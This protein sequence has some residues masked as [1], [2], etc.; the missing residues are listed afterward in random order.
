MKTPVRW[1]I[2]VLLVAVALL[3]LITAQDIRAN[4]AVR[5]TP[6]AI[7]NAVDTGEVAAL[8]RAAA[9][10]RIEASDLQPSLAFIAG[11]NDG[12]DFRLA[13]LLRA[14]LAYAHAFSPAADTALKAQLLAFP[15]WMDARGSGG[16]MVY[17]SEN[18]QALFSSAEFL[19]GGLY[20]DVRF[21]DG[22]T[23]AA[24]RA[25]A[26]GRLLFWLD[27]R[28]RYGFS[29]WN[30]HYYGEDI[31][32]LTNLIDFAGDAEIARKAE[33]IL[34]LLMADLATHAIK[35]EFIAASGRLYET[36]AKTGDEGVR[37]V[38][39]HAF[40]QPQDPQ[41]ATGLEIN[42][43][44][45]RYRAPPVLA[46]IAADPGPVVVRAS[47]GR[48]LS[49]L[50]SDRTLA[51]QERRIMALWGMEAFTNPEAINASLRHIRSHGLLGN[52]FLAG[53][54]QL[55]Y[56]VLSATGALPWLSRA[57]DLPTNGTVLSRANTY[58]WRTPDL[59]MS[60]TQAFRPGGF[61]N[62][63]RVF[64]TTFGP[65]L[66]L[67]H[68]HPAV[69]PGE[70]PPNGNSPG[71]WTGSGR[72]PLSCQEGPINLTLYRLP[73]SPGFGRRT[74]LEFT[75]LYAPRARFDQVVT[76]PNRLFLR[77]GDAWVA[78]SAIAPLEIAGPDE[79][80]QRGRD[81]AWVTEA[82]S[83]R[84]ETF[85]AFVARVRSG[86]IRFKN[87]V[88]T[89][90]SGGHVLTAGM[91][92]GC[93]RDGQP[94]ETSYPRLASPYGDVPRDPATVRLAFAGHSLRL[95]FDRMRREVR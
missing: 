28:W 82:S 11:R 93:A 10:G 41:T 76:D 63:H 35:G 56:R 89:Y 78:V 50:N 75:H 74:L 21:A 20:P 62:Q 3:A 8:K 6:S 12:S 77:R 42:L 24:H 29:E 37:R 71:Y 86:Q 13:V 85:A 38:L 44:L 79:I 9:G 31:P 54:R 27:Q 18:H 46:A 34:D 40:V 59:V 23:G 30:S 66:T 94:L 60:T 7:A 73:K 72:L 14:R 5:V 61:G 57:L 51:D 39:R 92:E 52:P 2:A 4:R 58:A 17:W 81:T 49:E 91:T 87:G 70:P 47:A 68:S 43:L 48:D 19:A 64:V 88:L 95:D 25:E 33:I 83:A 32:A 22:R 67:F 80:L 84:V 15:Y 36:N 16:P 26:R 90:S 55:N 69:R 53:F 45:S 65:G 1:L